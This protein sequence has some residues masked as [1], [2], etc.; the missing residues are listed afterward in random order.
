MIPGQMG[1]A[2]EQQQQQLI[3]IGRMMPPDYD[4]H[5]QAPIAPQLT[6]NANMSAGMN[7]D[8]AGPGM[9]M[10][11]SAGGLSG[12]RLLELY[13]AWNSVKRDELLNMLRYEQYYHGTDHWTAQQAAV[14]KLRGQPPTYFN[15]IRKKIDSYIGIEQRLRRDPKVQPRTPMHD[16]DADAAEAALR[17]VHDTNK[18]HV[19]FSECGRDYF[20]RGIGSMWAGVERLKSGELRVIKKRIPGVNFIYDP[21]S[22]EWDFSD[23][24][25]MG[26]WGWFDIDDAEE[27][28]TRLG[29]EDS[30]A[31]MRSM[32]GLSASHGGLGSVGVPGE[33]ARVKAGW[34]ARNLG[35]VRLVHMY[36]R[37][38]GEWRCTY[39]CGSTV[40]YD[41][42]S[43]YRDEDS[44]SAQPI[45][46]ASCNVD[47]TGE[48]YGVVKDL[49]PIQDSINQRH[50][51]LQ[52]MLSAR[53]IIFETGAVKDVNKAREEAKRADGMVELNP[54]GQGASA[55]RFEIVTMDREIQGQAMLL[56]NSIAMMQNY[57]PNPALLG[58]DREAASGRALL[59]SQNA[60][61]T[62]MAPVFDR[63]REFKLCSFRLDWR[64]IRQFWR[65]EKW[66]RV[67][68]DEKGVKFFA[69]N[70]K[71]YNTATG[72][73]TIRNDV[74]KMD[75][76]LIVD[77]G[78]DTVTM[79]EE[80]MANLTNLGPGAVPPKVIVQLSGVRNKDYLFK[81]LD[82]A[83]APNPEIAA[84]QKRMAAL[85]EMLN[86]A[87]VD[88][89]IAKT[90]NTR[91]NTVKTMMEAMAPPEVMQAFPLQYGQPSFA[92]QS[93]EAFMQGS[94]M[95]QG[96]G[97]PGGDPAAMQP[98]NENAFMEPEDMSG[99][100]MPGEEPQFG[101]EGGLP[102]DR[103]SAQAA[104]P[105][106]GTRA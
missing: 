79:T 59:A 28:F 50:S 66:V 106:A 43:I 19:V 65:A 70:Q 77:E 34:W 41:E 98:A 103:M 29:R 81:L 26:E 33:M 55:K 6:P 104:M 38:R 40:L 60:G 86:A 101:E 57:G 31:L 62:E 12:A 53:Q 37:H 22:L 32:A 21:R 1:G 48:R 3:P 52:W 96:G 68:D 11:P 105:R 18:S 64:L 94:D 35:R 99:P 56:E 90:E 63:H 17:E 95:A 84:M 44:N 20:V 85:E 73:I 61:M 39:F 49:I 80:L 9:G 25:F 30:A 91:A 45:L 27:L 54:A 75:C 8:G 24:K 42:P 47:Q 36:Y 72:E 46:A 100:A 88:S 102:M 5:A 67:M 97:M 23:A 69:L 15:E 51:K 93:F 4:P 83:Q 13:E 16:F 78:P 10:A 74:A 76:D 92:D 58:K 14:L 89:E 82:E 2:P 7:T 87:K 71:M